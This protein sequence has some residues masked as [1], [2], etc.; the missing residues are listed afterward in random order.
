MRSTRAILCA[1]VLASTSLFACTHEENQPAPVAAAPQPPPPPPQPQAPPQ[2][3]VEDRARSLLLAAD[4]QLK[5]LQEARSHATDDT[6]RESLSRQIGEVSVNRDRLT[7]DLAVE[8]PDSPNIARAMSNLQRAMRGPSAGAAEP[9]PPAT[10]EP[11]PPAAEPQPQGPPP[12]PRP[13]SP[14]PEDQP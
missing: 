7:A 14:P 1:T 5:D 3:S 10:T 6:R 2:A 11:Q 4:L 9:Q 13:P 12:E 8:P